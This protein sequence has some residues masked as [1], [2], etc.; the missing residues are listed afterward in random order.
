MSREAIVALMCEVV[1]GILDREVDE[2]TVLSGRELHT[3][4]SLGI[5]Q[6]IAGVEEAV[7]EQYNKS[8]TLIG[9]RLYSRK[10]SPLST[11]GTLA[12]YVVELIEEAK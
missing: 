11:V 7:Y 8:I 1:G 3:L 4:D 2:G 9:E 5:A 10:H 6:L 12:D